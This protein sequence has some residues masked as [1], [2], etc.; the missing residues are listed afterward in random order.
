MAF[1]HWRPPV[2]RSLDAA[3]VVVT[4]SALL[5]GA[6][7]I[8]LLQ[9]AGTADPQWEGLSLIVVGW[10]YV[11]A[12]VLAW[13]RRPSNRTG[14]LVVAGGWSLLL[15][16]LGNTA[17][18]A[19][20]A[21]S[22]VVATVSLAVAFH[23]LLAFPSGRLS[24]GAPRWTVLAVYAVSVVLQA[25]I[26]LFTPRPAP[27]DLLLVSAQPGLASAGHLV[28]A[29]AGVCVVVAA[30]A[31][32]A[33]RLRR[34]TPGQR[35]T[36][37]P[38]YA[39]GILAVVF[40]PVSANVLRPLLGLNEAELGG[41]QLLALAGIPV[42]FSLAVLRGGFARTGEM[43]E[44]AT[45][46]GTSGDGRPGLARV[47]AR[48]LGD[49]SVQL[50]FWVPERGGYVDAAGRTTVL[51]GAEGDRAAVEVEL[52][53]QPVGAVVYDARLI[54][55]PELVRAAGRVV[56]LALD[57]ERLTAELRA[58]EDELRR[59]RSRL[60]QAAD[61]ER[62]RI[63]RDLHD[64]MQVRLVLLGLQAA[65][66]AS[67]PGDDAGAEAL[68]VGLDDAAA[69]LRRLVHDLM[70]AGLVEGGLAAAAQDLVDR[71]PVPT[72]LELSGP[73][74]RLPPTVESTAYYVLAEALTNALKHARA[75]RLNV[76][77]AD[78]DGRLRVEVHDDG[79]G[80]ALAASGLRGL[81]DRVDTLGGSLRIDSPSGFGTS[82]VL[83]LPCA[84]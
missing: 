65:R 47:L 9:A 17:V 22:Q 59:S 36:L 33:G 56:A 55:D 31:V 46:L 28:Q 15:V 5:F 16:A 67:R 43:E 81:G 75:A 30:V 2:A 40:I 11:A 8:A 70:P 68:R 69:E 61:A 29:L 78:G 49:D 53:G 84:S 34:A 52:A 42:A 27:Y 57:R 4:G 12:G 6:V 54:A 72:T 76:R 79:V 58:S 73:V 25:P 1:T 60:I 82:V 32:L 66:L 50:A 10:C 77:L 51:P 80:G 39:Y 14:L 7:E 24:S 71:M 26:W 35:R 19:L 3:L 41:L 74:R 38:L 18:P 48:A 23:L 83:E 64:G 63:A 37:G 21:V 62:R 44:L 20:L 45:W 13:W